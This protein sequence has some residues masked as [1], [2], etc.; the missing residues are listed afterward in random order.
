MTPVE[1]GCDRSRVSLTPLLQL[2]LVAHA[3]G[4]RI[5]AFGGRTDT[6]PQ[7]H[8]S[9]TQ[10]C[11]EIGASP[12]PLVLGGERV[13]FSYELWGDWVRYHLLVEVAAD[14][15]A[16]LHIRSKFPR[17]HHTIRLY[18]Q[19]LLKT[20]AHSQ[21]SRAPNRKHHVPLKPSSKLFHGNATGSPPL[22]AKAPAREKAMR[23]P[24]FIAN[25]FAFPANASTFSIS[26]N[27]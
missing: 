8:G 15:R 18:G 17:W 6:C 3:L 1:P 19:R 16:A 27:V 7:P 25:S 20:G 12:G 2:P 26:K 11:S 5:P 23:R 22:P 4:R 21:V 13:C 24:H 9:G 14:D 10:A